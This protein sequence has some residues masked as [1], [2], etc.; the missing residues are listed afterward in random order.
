MIVKEPSSSDTMAPSPTIEMSGSGEG[1]TD[2]PTSGAS[3]HQLVISLLFV[4]VAM[5]ALIM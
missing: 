3:H 4:M 5:V 2:D 1:S